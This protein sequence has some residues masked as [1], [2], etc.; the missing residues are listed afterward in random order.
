MENNTLVHDA[1]LTRRT[2]HLWKDE[3]MHNDVV[4]RALESAHMA[5]CHRYTWPWRFYRCGAKSRAA[6]FSLSLELKRKG[7]PEL[8]QRMIEK[9]IQ[10][11][12]NPAELIVVTLIYCENDF[13]ARENYAAASCAIQN[14]A[15]SFHADGFASKWSTG[16]LTTHSKT[17]ELLGIDSTKEEIIG[18]IWAG[19]PEKI[20]EAPDRTPID[21]HIIYID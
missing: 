17:Y 11:V 9:M 1:I 4:N 6:V 3:P 8:P 14:M 20:P 5:P 19:V 16:G 15:L 18:F 10:K 2:V 21:D 7:G 13:T 12:K